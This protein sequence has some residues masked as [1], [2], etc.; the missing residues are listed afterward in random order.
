MLSVVCVYIFYPLISFKMCTY[1]CSYLKHYDS[2]NKI[3]YT[4]TFNMIFSTLSLCFLLF[5][6]CMKKEKYQTFSKAHSLSFL[7]SFSLAL[8]PPNSHCIPV[9]SF[10]TKIS[11]K[12][13]KNLNFINSAFILPMQ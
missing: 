1:V 9:K 5:F 8:L 3:S 12:R 7:F 11:H 4:H 6:E 2:C 10:I 13:H